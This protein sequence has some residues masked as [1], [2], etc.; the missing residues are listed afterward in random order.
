MKNNLIF[1]IS[2][3]II[4]CAI[5]LSK[6]YANKEQETQIKKF[7][8]QFEQY[9]EKSIKGNEIATIINKAVDINERAYIKKDEKGKYIQNDESS[10]NIEIKITDLAQ[11]KIYEM[12]TLYSGGISEFVK[13]YGQIPF[14]VTNIMYNSKGKV[15][16][17]LFEQISS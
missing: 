17:M 3:V 10:I 4:I 9:N 2:I 5:L 16:Y 11:G 12:E 13:Y 6:Y 1:I 8:S 14:K 7:N 15:K